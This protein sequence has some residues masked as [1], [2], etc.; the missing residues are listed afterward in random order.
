MPLEVEYEY[1]SV[2][3]NRHSAA[4]DWSASSG[5]LAFGADQNVAIWEPLNET[6]R[7]ITALL[8]GHSSKVTAVKFF[9]GSQEPLTENLVTGSANGELFLW[10]IDGPSHTWTLLD[11]AK[12]HD[13]TVN[14]IAAY[15]GKGILATGGA[16]ANL[17]LWRL[18]QRKLELVATLP[19]KP[20]FI[21]LALAVG[22]FPSG[23]SGFLAVGGT[24]NEIHIFAVEELAS[25]PQI[26]LCASLKGHEAWIR[27]LALTPH[28]EGGFLLA[29]ASQDKY[30]R[31]WRFQE[32]DAVLSNKPVD[33]TTAA[34]TG[35]ALT[36]KVQ[37]VATADGKY[38]ITFDALLLGHEDWVYTA[39]WRPSASSPQLLT[40]SADGS[41]SIWEADPASGIWISIS[42]LGE[43]ST[44]KGAT[45]ATGSAGGFWTGLW[46]PDGSMV[47]CLG[48]TGSWR[49]WQY[50]EQTQFWTQRHAISG[51]VKSANGICWAPDGSYLLSTSSD[52]TTRL[53]A[54][55][56]RG[57]KRSWHEFSRP[58]IH[59][60][61]LNCIASTSPYQFSSGADE[62]LL[63][64]F[65]E[66]KDIA[67]MLH[68]L[69]QIALPPEKTQLPDTAAI[70]VLGLSNKA[71]DDNH[72]DQRDVG[73]EESD[74]NTASNGLGPSL[75]DLQE[76]PTEDLLSRHT[77]W[78]EHEKLYGHGYEISEAATPADGSVLATACKASSIDHAV[79][80]L[81]D[82]NNW[83]EIKPPL[84]AHSLTVTRLA[85]SSHP[86][87][88]LLSVSRDRQWA[89]FQRGNG[90]VVRNWTRVAICPKAHSR[91]IL[92]AVWVS[93]DHHLTFATAGRD[94]VVKLWSGQEGAD[95]P[96]FA[97]KAS[98]ARKS[99]VTAISALYNGNG[100]SV[101]AVGEDDGRIS[102]HLVNCTQDGLEVGASLE[103][104]SWFCPSKT[105]HRLAWRPISDP[106]E[107]DRT[108]Q[109]AIASEDGSVRILKID[110]Q[111]LSSE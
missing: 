24:R 54:E 52:Q 66:P 33:P 5:L 85:F 82:T 2:G 31:L 55:W 87:G 49:L 99:A 96:E 37:T 72:G 90:D 77:L 101:L 108:G 80:R 34:T 51:H 7:G 47:T 11:K 103:V 58:Q 89:V 71:M 64:V 41:L 74:P 92:D 62:K 9:T 30:V 48:R 93:S 106:G 6:G 102:L 28:P 79:I 42:R 39:T 21:P 59:G 19:L 100:R 3:G 83:H 65:N 44:H 94:K 98:I 23:D 26:R 73:T 16:D 69:C 56:K 14:T 29:S 107:D 36:A 12:A 91:M 38:S 61:D 27:N 46:S 22:L 15:D 20:R 70:P 97:C 40:A 57:T 25:A 111:S 8:S 78:P 68:N 104:D 86:P 4:A 1:I 63:R 81:Y 105:V 53:H 84:T 76:P 35:N 32:G 88:Y 75:L 10:K 110:L 109:L 43:I 45:T 17:K 50:S 18:G 67:K 13:G 95:G 60:Y